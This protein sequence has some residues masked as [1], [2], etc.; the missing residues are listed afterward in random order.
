MQQAFD[1]IGSW[2]DCW[3]MNEGCMTLYGSGTRAAGYDEKKNR[4]TSC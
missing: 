2:R 4:V 3:V 1:E